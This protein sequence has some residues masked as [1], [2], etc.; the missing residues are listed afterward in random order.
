M[1][2][3]Y[4]TRR[5]IMAQF[6]KLISVGVPVRNNV[7]TIRH[8]LDSIEKQSI[9]NCEVLISVDSSD[10]GTLEICHEYI[11]RNPTW[12]IANHVERMGLYKNFEYVFRNTNSKYFLWLAGDDY[13]TK[14]FIEK[15]VDF[16]EKNLDFVASSGKPV[17]I[18]SEEPYFPLTINLSGIQSERILNFLKNAGISHNVFY[19]VARREEMEKFKYLG[20]S[21]LA[22]DW[23]YIVQLVCAGKVKTDCETNIFFGVD[24]VSRQINAR[25]AFANTGLERI[26]PYKKFLFTLVQ[27]LVEQ[28]IFSKNILFWILKY[29][30]RDLMLSC[31][32][33]LR[34]LINK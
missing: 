15:N 13:I 30:L 33:K 26:F 29:S 6:S 27:K 21:F 14:D 20:K 25:V 34:L 31:K 8:T 4:L 18:F 7:K 11:E 23:S 19:S 24:G 22:A 28:R 3:I 12:K 16:L 32:G 1:S 2:R 9:R 5:G 17:F 10:D